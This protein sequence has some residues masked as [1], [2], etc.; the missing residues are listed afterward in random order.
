MFDQLRQS[1]KIPPK[2]QD[3]YERVT[4]AGMK[5]LF[6]KGTNEKIMAMIG[7]QPTGESV[8]AA[9]AQV[10]QTIIV[11]AQDKMPKEILLPAGAF[12]I[13]QVGQMLEE[14]GETFDGSMVGQALMEMTKQVM[15]HYGGT[16]EAMKKMHAQEPPAQEAAEP[17]QEP[18]AE[19]EAEPQ[20]LI[21]R[22]A[23]V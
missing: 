22:R 17:Q 12:L 19:E 7:E 1:I 5:I 18:P 14:S 2:L 10:L 9:V 8:G 11:Q 13:T 21:Q 4:A 3:A 6:S 23:M 15:A 16:P 20:G